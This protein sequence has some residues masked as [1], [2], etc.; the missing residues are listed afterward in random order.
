MPSQE[1]WTLQTV[2][3][4]QERFYAGRLDKEVSLWHDA[5]KRWLR[6]QR[7]LPCSLGISVH[8]AAAECP[9]CGQQSLGHC[10]LPATLPPLPA[11]VLL[12]HCPVAFR[13]D[14][15]SQVLRGMA[16]S[17]L[18][19]DS[20]LVPFPLLTA[21]LEK[22]LR[23]FDL[24]SQAWCPDR[25]VSC[26]TRLG[27]PTGRAWLRRAG[28][29]LRKIGV[30]LDLVFTVKRRKLWGVC[31]QVQDHRNCHCWA[32][33]GDFVSCAVTEPHEVVSPLMVFHLF[34]SSCVENR[35]TVSRPCL[36]ACV[37]R[38]GTNFPS[39]MSTS[40]LSTTL[41][42]TGPNGAPDG[43][44]ACQSVPASTL[45]IY[46]LA[47]FF[48]R[49]LAGCG[50]WAG[51][52]REH[53]DFPSAAQPSLNNWHVS[54][55]RNRGSQRNAEEL[56]RAQAAESRA[57]L[58]PSRFLCDRDGLLEWVSLRTTITS[59]FETVSSVLT[60]GTYIF[61]DTDLFAKVHLAYSRWTEDGE[62]F[63]LGF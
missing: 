18:S 44:P 32:G 2:W 43:H 25:T 37:L 15:G 58:F 38:W 17:F 45:I 8:Q 34:D 60:E 59:L 53:T 28:R 24:L 16:F 12:C 7:Y 27:C 51:K 30:T 57:R 21:S 35:K 56:S 39:L 41:G 62:C 61:W 20:H 47:P 31:W 63:F 29:S 11:T 33:P 23:H 54:T 55:T 49:K 22:T 13:L 42:S 1:A 4:A 46:S 36:P 26:S 5:M 48:P 10:C 52:V 50:G 6:G 14:P 19:L 9:G 3:R 40:W